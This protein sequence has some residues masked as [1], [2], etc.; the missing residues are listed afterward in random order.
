MSLLEINKRY[1]DLAEGTCCLSCGGAINHSKP[2]PG[3]VCVD[4]GSGRGTD[5]LRLAEDVGENGFVYGIDVSDGMIEKANR[6][7]EKLNV[8]NVEFVKSDLENI[9]LP[10]KT[11]D[12]IISNCTINHASDKDAVWREIYRILKPGG[13]FVI[14]DIYSLK[15]VPEEYRN[16]P[17][18]VAEC[19]AGAVT[20]REYLQTIED[21][22]LALISIV[23]ESQP[24]AKGKI[25]VASFTILGIRP[26]TKC[27]C[28]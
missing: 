6:N 1:S 17:V 27:S 23:E 26:R 3:E 12:L 21:T 10:S 13:R 7:K 19:W 8:R 14:S 20:K 9:N 25:E 22:G 18:A 11:A 24:Y 4:L 28:S 15:P 5:V 2:Q 16:D